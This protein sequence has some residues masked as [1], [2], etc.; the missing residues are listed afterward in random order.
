MVEITDNINENVLFIVK[1]N[2]EYNTKLLLIFMLIVIAILFIVF[3][4]RLL[5]IDKNWS[6]M[7]AK[8]GLWFGWT[9]IFS[10]LLLPLMLYLEVSLDRM[11]VLIGGLYVLIL[12]I[13]FLTIKMWMLELT[14][15]LIRKSG[16]DIPKRSL[17][18]RKK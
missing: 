17:R 6:D 1:A 8:A 5:S 13:A 18:W 7:V 4:K 12:T 10:S 11:F 9:I 2:Q 16:F 15:A 3:H 14:V